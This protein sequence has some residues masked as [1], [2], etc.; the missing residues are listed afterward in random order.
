MGLLLFSFFGERLCKMVG[1]EMP[2]VHAALKDNKMMMVIAFMIVGQISGQLVATGAF[3][4]E[5]NG[6]VV[7]SKLK[8]G[9]MPTGNDIIRAMGKVGL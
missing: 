6:V 7:Y 1:V 5:V 9:R 4:L 8:L 3:E 2:A